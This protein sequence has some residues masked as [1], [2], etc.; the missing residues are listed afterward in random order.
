MD[1]LLTSMSVSRA[2]GNGANEAMRRVLAPSRR[3]RWPNSPG[4]AAGGRQM[5]HHV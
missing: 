2:A 4:L 3:R 5:W 1:V